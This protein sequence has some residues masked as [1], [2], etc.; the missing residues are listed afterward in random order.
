MTWE[1]IAPRFRA[2][3]LLRRNFARRLSRRPGIT[4]STMRMVLSS[5]QVA[6]ET[7][8]VF[9]RVVMPR[10]GERMPP[11]LSSGVTPPR[12]RLSI[13]PSVKL[14]AVP[15]RPRSA[16]PFT[17]RA[18]SRSAASIPASA[19]APRTAACRV[20]PPSNTS[21]PTS[22]MRSWFSAAACAS[23]S[24]TVSPL[25]PTTAMRS[26]RFSEAV[27]TWVRSAWWTSAAALSVTTMRTL[28][29][30]ARAWKASV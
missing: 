9:V 5:R 3:F 11:R 14:A 24:L 16:A 18:G 30:S 19:A 10:T 23:M 4:S 15:P 6:S 25:P 7:S 2:V 13:F 26:L 29:Q 1:R 28:S 8:P 21:G 12:T 20:P 17:G 27:S 22:T